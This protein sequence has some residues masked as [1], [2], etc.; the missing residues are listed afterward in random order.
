MAGILTWHRDCLRYIE[1]ELRHPPG[2]PG[3]LGAPDGLG[4]SAARAFRPSPRRRLGRGERVDHG[5]PGAAGPVRPGAR[6]LGRPWRAGAASAGPRPYA[7]VPLAVRTTASCAIDLWFMTPCVRG[8]RRGGGRW[9][10]GFS[11]RRG[12]RFGVPAGAGSPPAG[13]GL[14]RAVAGRPAAGRALGGGERG[15]AAGRRPA[16]DADRPRLAAAGGPALARHPR[17]QCGHAADRPRRCLRHRR[18]ELAGRARR[19]RAAG[20]GPGDSRATSTG[21]SCS[22]SP[23]PPR[24]RW[25]PWGCRRW[26]CVRCMAFAGQRVDA[27]LGRVRLLGEHEIGPALLSERTRLPAGSVR[28]LADHL[29]RVF[30]EYE[31]PAVTRR[32]RPHRRPAA[33]GR[34][35]RPLRPRR[36]AGRR[37]RRGAPG[38]H[39]AVDD[40]PPPRPARAGAPQ[41]GRSRPDQR[42]GRHRQD[43]RR[44]APRGLSRPAHHRPRPVRH[45]RQ[46]PAPRAGHLPQAMAP[47][48]ADRIDFRSLHSWAQDYPARPRRPRPPA[49]GQGRDR[50]QPRLETR[51][52]GQ[53]PGRDR[54]AAPLL[55]GGDRLRHQGPRHHLLRRVRRAR[56]PSP[57]GRSAPPAPA[58]RLGPVRGVRGAAHRA[59]RARLQRR[60][61]PRA[62]GGGRP[63]PATARYAAVIVDEV[64]DLTLVGVRLL[65]ALVGDSPN[66]LLLV[67]DGQQ[68]VYPGGFRLSDAGIDI[69]GDRGQVLRTNYRNSK[70]ILDTALSRG[71][72]GRLRGHRRAAHPRPP[73]RRPDLP[74]RP[75]AARGAARPSPPRPGAAG[76][77][78]RPDA[79]AAGPTPPCCAPSKRAIEPLPAPARPGRASASARWSTT[80]ATRSR[81]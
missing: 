25:R 66:G 30:P 2:S 11:G 6:P 17:G 23:R 5:R 26:R 44:P 15:R 57:P 22:R 33:D 48:V 38:P 37:P 12:R 35:R 81:P 73:G 8:E 9:R 75:G 49:Q 3:W 31:D 28:A 41:L 19:P 63:H 71:R 13:A 50:L 42:P 56:P 45:L 34:G 20:C 70:E 69:R 77:A 60:A 74:R 53:L 47:A 67:G 29:A 18:Q 65:H 39:R 21:A 4:T 59:R 64:Q 78:A 62:G 52:P 79:A 72:R 54:P 58:G 46:Q 14:T 16:A 43:G 51:R 7:P 55:A 40:L 68:A 80:T 36:T 32:H 10:Q 24:A 76:R 27:E 1:P 61:L